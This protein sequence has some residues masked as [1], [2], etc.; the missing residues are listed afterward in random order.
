MVAAEVTCDT[1]AVYDLQYG[2]CPAAIGHSQL[3]AGGEN[4]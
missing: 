2:K 4:A 1:A 3:T